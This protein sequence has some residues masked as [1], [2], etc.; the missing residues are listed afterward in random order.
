MTRCNNNKEFFLLFFFLFF[1]SSVRQLNL[2]SLRWRHYILFSALL[3]T[4]SSVVRLPC[5]VLEQVMP[6]MTE[7]VQQVRTLRQQQRRQALVGRN[8]DEGDDDNG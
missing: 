6:V 4:C 2:L 8:N 5:S 1:R 3:L 7:L